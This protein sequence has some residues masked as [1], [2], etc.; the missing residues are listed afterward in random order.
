M[1]KEKKTVKKTV[2]KK[3][4]TKRVVKGTVTITHYSKEPFYD[5]TMRP[6]ITDQKLMAILETILLSVQHKEYEKRIPPKGRGAKPKRN[7]RIEP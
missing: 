5:V 7:R 1:P 2:K 4:A 3:T 6:T